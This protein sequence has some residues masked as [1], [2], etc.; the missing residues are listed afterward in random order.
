MN[1]AM[2][3]LQGSLQVPQQTLELKALQIQHCNHPVQALLTLCMKVL[4]WTI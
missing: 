3:G 1:N 4:P 2:S